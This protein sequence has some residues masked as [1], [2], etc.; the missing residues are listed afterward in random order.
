MMTLASGCK[1]QEPNPTIPVELVADSSVKVLLPV[2]STWYHTPYNRGDT[3]NW[4]DFRSPEEEPEAGGQAAGAEGEIRAMIDEYNEVAAAMDFEELILYHVESQQDE[5]KALFDASKPLIAKLEELEQVIAEK[6]P[7]KKDELG[8][9]FAALRGSASNKQTLEDFQQV[10][11]TEAT[12][13]LSQG[14]QGWQVR[15]Q[16]VEDEWFIELVDMEMISQVQTGMTML[17]NGLDQL[18]PAIK[19]DTMPAEMFVQQLEMMTGGMQAGGEG[20]TPNDEGNDNEGDDDEGAE[21]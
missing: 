17:S 3:A 19:N 11:E 6:L 5:L 18:L 14:Q 2:K 10:S 12:G 15:F 1:E 20:E 8:E 7:D 16:N 21:E 9:K 13:R 4:I